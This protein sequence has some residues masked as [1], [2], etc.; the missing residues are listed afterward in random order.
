MVELLPEELASQPDLRGFLMG[1]V[2]D[3]AF[4]IDWGLPVFVTEGNFDDKAIEGPRAGLKYLQQ[5]FK[6]RSGQPYWTAVSACNS[7]LLGRSTPDHARV[8]FIAAYADHM[9]KMGGH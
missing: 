7:A 6:K 3:V 2:I 8:C 4:A 5:N 1:S 9:C